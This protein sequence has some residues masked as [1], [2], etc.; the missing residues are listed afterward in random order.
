MKGVD[1]LIAEGNVLE[2]QG[3]LAEAEACYRKALKLGG[4]S[5]RAYL[6]IGNVYSLRQQAVEAQ[7]Y[8]LKALELDPGNPGANANLGR[9]ALVNE[10]FAVAEKY[11]RRA[12]EGV[13]GSAKAE[14]LLGLSEACQQSGRLEE[15]LVACREAVD[16]VPAH[17]WAN[18]KLGHLLMMGGRHAEATAALQKAVDYMPEDADV[19][20]WLGKL[21]CDQGDVEEAMRHMRVATRI[22]PGDPY[23]LGMSVF[24]MNYLPQVTGEQLFR[25]HRDFA[26][27]FCKPYY[28]TVECQELPAVDADKLRIGYVSSDFRQH[29]V[30]RFVETLLLHHDVERFEVH[31]FY[32][33]DKTDTVTERLKRLSHFW[34]DIAEMEDPDVIDLIRTVG[35][36]V[37]VDLNG[38]TEGHRL[39]VFARRPAPIQITWLGYL[40]TT[41]LD[42][43]NYRICDG[44]TDPPG[45]TEQYHTEK[46]LR[47]VDSQWCHAPYT[48]LPPMTPAP[49]LRNGRVTLGSF[50]YAG[51]LNNAVLAL[52]GK[53][54]CAMP[55]ARI[56]LAAIPEGY[57]RQRV[58][59]VLGENGVDASRVEFLPRLPYREYLEAVGNVDLALD[60]FPYNG[61]TTS[62][63][64]LIMGVPFI[65][66]RGNHSIARGG[67]SIL[68]SIG[69]PELI[70][71]TREEYVTKVCELAQSG[72]KLVQLRGELRK[73]LMTSPLMDGRRFTREIED[74]FEECWQ[75]ARRF[76]L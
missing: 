13:S 52:W 50:N 56:R 62:I 1:A 53:V 15:A 19:H 22:D 59:R 31:C 40:G 73:R 29:P 43:M 23:K 9:I 45:L 39:P 35:I 75:Q 72:E 25:A 33:H 54:L 32:N 58:L 36:H 38:L 5:A 64:M 27:R 16:I 24:T 68:S 8:Y 48:E 26:N 63:D 65:S 3:R 47:V 20:V 4:N 67:S 70:A 7:K 51:K 74:R 2:D 42:T 14:A 69:L 12:C 60:P 18:K 6:N 10:E 44:H 28:P 17:P 37:L 46:L 57:A 41:G 76:R 55:G 21:L 49:F 66:L 30:S 61:G 11:F 71:E 34:H